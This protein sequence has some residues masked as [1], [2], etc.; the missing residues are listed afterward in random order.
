MLFVLC[1]MADKC[2]SGIFNIK[3]ILSLSLLAH[4]DVKPLVCSSMHCVAIPVEYIYVD[5]RVNVFYV[6][7]NY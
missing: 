1:K 4:S 7:L 2:G 3:Q 5:A 6:Q